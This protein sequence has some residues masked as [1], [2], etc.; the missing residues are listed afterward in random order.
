MR[1]TSSE[2]IS[3]HTKA[4]ATDRLRFFQK[5]FR[6]AANT[7]SGSIENVFLPVT[8]KVVVLNN[9]D[10]PDSRT[11]GLVTVVVTDAP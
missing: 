7:A 5:I 6:Q 1:P 8:L 3:E 9:R 2:E 10:T 4:N 11:W